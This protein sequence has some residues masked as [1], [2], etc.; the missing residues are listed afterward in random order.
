MN[1]KLADIVYQF[2]EVLEKEEWK[3]MEEAIEKIVDTSLKNK[4]GLR[5]MLSRHPRWDNDTLRI[6]MPVDTNG[7]RLDVPERMKG[8]R[9]IC[10]EG[11]IDTDPLEVFE[12]VLTRGGVLT[13]DDCDALQAKGYNG[14]KTGQ[15]IGRAINAWA[16][17]YSFCNF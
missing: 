14:G 11:E 12:S 6:T 9:S 15:K 10:D 8:F 1:E 16:M 3:P 4:E 5:E 2:C 17:V 7:E 13:V